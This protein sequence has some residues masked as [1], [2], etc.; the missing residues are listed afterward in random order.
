[1]AL[2][3]VRTSE[4][5]AV[6]AHPIPEADY[7]FDAIAIREKIARSFCLLLSEKLEI[8]DSLPKL[9]VEKA[10][11]LVKILDDERAKFADVNRK[12]ADHLALILRRQFRVVR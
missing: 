7:P 12:H 1:M 11:R 5:A 4:I 10:A 6:L 8:I 3:G 9:P 2:Y